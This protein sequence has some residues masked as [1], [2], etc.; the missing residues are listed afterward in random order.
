M[1]I[2]KDGKWVLGDDYYTAPTC[3][4]CHMGSFI[5]LNG[6][7]AASSHNVGDR[8]SWNLRAPVSSKL[9]RVTFTD[10]SVTDI[11][12][13]MPPRAGQKAKYKTYV[14]EDDR[15][16]KIVT[17]KTI[18]AVTTWKRR[19][20]NMQ[21]VC[22]SC[23]SIN[24]IQNFYTQFDELIVL[25][26]EKFAVPATDIMNELIADGVLKADAPF[27][28]TVQWVYWELWHHEGRRARHGASMMGPDYT[29]WH[30][31]YEVSKHFYDEFLPAIIE[32]A[33]ETSH[34][35]KR[36]WERKVTSLLAQPEHVWLKG[37]SEREARAQG[38]NIRVAKMPMTWVARALE[39]DEARGFMKA[40]VDADTDQILGAAILSIEGGE[41]MTVLQMAMMGGLPYTALRDAIF[42]HPTL[43]ESLNNLFTTLDG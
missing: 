43:A 5:K 14:R 29:H 10:G 24:Q 4:T 15:M 9:N 25:Y 12:G 23:H 37:L 2:L 39:S 6:S 22:K 42:A 17:Q 7:V 26:N 16:K 41:V 35:M 3:S 18:K 34:A 21:A 27:E 11:S 36:K 32:A 1:N 38:R 13:E 40:I 19:R 30:G 33:E 8:I 31:M 20:A 28:K